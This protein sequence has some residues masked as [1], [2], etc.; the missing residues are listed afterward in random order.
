MPYKMSWAVPQRV[1]HQHVYGT[2]TMDELAQANQE[3]MLYM[4]RADG[5]LL[6]HH[7]LNFNGYEG[8]ELSLFKL[9]MTTSVLKYVKHSSLGWVLMAGLNPTLNRIGGLF[10][11]IMGTR[12]KAFEGGDLEPVISFLQFR[13]TSL[14]N[15]I[16]DLSE[17]Q[18]EAS[19]VSSP[20]ESQVS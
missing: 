5:D 8:A 6:V 10:Y 14:V 7:I 15:T 16:F 4:N 2:L 3:I 13:D 20:G 18:R 9:N 19:S 1:V 11:G 12:F 17:S